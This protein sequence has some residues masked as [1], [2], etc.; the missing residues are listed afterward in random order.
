MT[1]LDYDTKATAVEIRKALRAAFPGVKFSLRMERG[2]GHGYMHLAWTD[3]PEEAAVSAVTDYFQSSRFD[4]MDDC[5]KPLPDKLV[6]VEGEQM[7]VTISYSCRG[8]LTHR[9]FSPEVKA[10]AE[11]QIR[12]AFPTVDQP[13]VWADA[14]PVP[15]LG[16]CLADFQ[17]DVGLLAYRLLRK[18]GNLAEITTG[19]G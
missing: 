2:T 3:G 9:E 13:R 4:G 10:W 15:V 18:V 8:V 19:N 14:L 11:A 1:T 12:A 16:H 5:D 7:P 17:A 6:F